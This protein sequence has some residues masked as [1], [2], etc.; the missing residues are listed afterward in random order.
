MCPVIH[1]CNRSSCQT[2]AVSGPKIQCVKCQKTCFLLCYGFEKL[3][4]GVKIALS[5]GCSIAVDPNSMCFTCSSCDASFL[6]DAL[7][8]RMEST[9]TETINTNTN[10]TSLKSNDGSPKTTLST[11]SM[12]ISNDSPMTFAQLKKEIQ[13]L[14]K[15]MIT[16]VKK[17]DSSATDIC[18][19]KS[20]SSDTHAM[21]KSINASSSV[22]INDVTTK[23]N[24]LL[25]SQIQSNVMLQTPSKT[26][27]F[28][29]IVKQQRI[30]QRNEN[31]Q[32]TTIKRRLN[33][34][35]S[36]KITSTK[37]KDIPP[38]KMGKRTG[39]FALAV[40]PAPVKTLRKPK[41][42]D[43]NEQNKEI[44]PFD[45]S[46]HV[47]RIA[48]SVTVDDM[49]NFIAS[50]SSLSPNVDFKCTRLVKKDQSVD[51]LSFISFKIDYIEAKCEV[52][53][54]EDFWPSG[55]LI[56]P[57]VPS[58]TFGD[59]LSTSP[60]NSSGRPSKLQKTTVQKNDSTSSVPENSTNN[61]KVQTNATAINISNSIDLTQTEH[62]ETA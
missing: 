55:A 34:D 47:S 13:L 62:M 32:T 11:K 60:G 37:P 22:M 45:K 1:I 38:A 21:V 52:L 25:P 50:E 4:N 8:D 46:L 59:F 43:S 35:K 15:T 49:N 48:T 29:H 3:G 2:K 16:V 40:A 6:T 39:S 19:L 9:K 51:S 20:I 56:R 33:E 24:E 58:R 12:P 7:N 30:E 14:N 42:V 53:T 54:E 44:S 36:T 57:F 23:L 31:R 27:S 26:T 10:Q 17:M 41:S 28:S 18:D 5:S 61:E